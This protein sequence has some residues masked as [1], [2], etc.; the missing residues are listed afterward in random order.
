MRPKAGRSSSSRG[1][2]P[3][4]TAYTAYTANCTL[5]NA[6][7]RPCSRIIKCHPSAGARRDMR[8]GGET[9]TKVHNQV[10]SGAERCV[11]PATCPQTA[12]ASLALLV[13]QTNFQPLRSMLYSM[14]MDVVQGCGRPCLLSSSYCRL[15]LGCPL[16]RPPSTARRRIETLIGRGKMR[17]MM[18]TEEK[19][20]ELTCSRR[21]DSNRDST[22]PRTRRHMPKMRRQHNKPRSLGLIT[23]FSHL[24]RGGSPF[25]LTKSYDVCWESLDVSWISFCRVRALRSP[26][27]FSPHD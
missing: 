13:M 22:E 10:V 27:F 17:M 3:L 25:R 12:G 14:D 6:Q 7:S 9:A 5:H 8:K 23:C 4:H 15:N 19:K 1:I 24:S 2:S 21:R 26:S 20:S 18:K 11:R 16:F